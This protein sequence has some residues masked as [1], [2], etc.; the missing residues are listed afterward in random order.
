MEIVDL[1]RIIGLTKNCSSTTGKLVGNNKPYQ[2]FKN[3]G[4]NCMTRGIKNKDSR[5][6][7]YS[8]NEGKA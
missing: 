8:L 3:K 6:K 4:K 1:I 2:K 5:R 7:V